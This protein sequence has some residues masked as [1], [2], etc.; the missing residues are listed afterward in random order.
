MKSISEI[1]D[2]NGV[3][4]TRTKEATHDQKRT[5]KGGGGEGMT[6]SIKL[7]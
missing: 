3:L 7:I 5:E 1:E 4:P 2:Q 6:Y